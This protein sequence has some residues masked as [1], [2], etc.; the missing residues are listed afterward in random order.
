MLDNRYAI[1]FI[2]GERPVMDL[3]YN[4]L[5]HPNVGDSADGKGGEYH[6]GE[7][8]MAMASISLQTGVEVPELPEMELS[9]ME[10]KYEILTEEEIEQLMKTE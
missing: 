7:V 8:T 4:L 2:R 5:K 6:H 1:L 10:Q 3:K 9:E